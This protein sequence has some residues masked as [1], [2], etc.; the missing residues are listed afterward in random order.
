[1]QQT[2]Y[3]VPSIIKLRKTVN[4][5][6]RLNLSV[7]DDVESKFREAVFKKKGMKKGNLTQS[8]EEAMLMWINVPNQDEGKIHKQ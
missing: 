7:N 6:G 5:M 3:F 2:L 8:V 4:V 1:M